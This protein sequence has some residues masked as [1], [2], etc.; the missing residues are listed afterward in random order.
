M[1]EHTGEMQY[2][3][4]GRFIISMQACNAIGKKSDL[5]VHTA[6]EWGEGHFFPHA[7]Y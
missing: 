3:E 6:T 1:Q 7:L 5:L 4:Q 2:S